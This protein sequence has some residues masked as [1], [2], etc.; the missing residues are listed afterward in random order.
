MGQFNTVC[1]V[2]NGLIGDQKFVVVGQAIDHFDGQGSRETLFP[3]HRDIVQLQ[4]LG[5]FLRS[6]PN[7]LIIT[8]LAAMQATSRLSEGIL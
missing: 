1:L 7:Y 2:G 3:V 8:H 6:I 4:R 5:I